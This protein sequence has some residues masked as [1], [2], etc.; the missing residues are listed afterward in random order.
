MTNNAGRHVELAKTP[1]TKEEELAAFDRLPYALRALIRYGNSNWSAHE[2]EQMVNRFGPA[3][4]AAKLKE[5]NAK[6]QERLERIYRG[7]EK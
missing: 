7:E 6:L 1:V 5:A 4:I 2:I 3:V